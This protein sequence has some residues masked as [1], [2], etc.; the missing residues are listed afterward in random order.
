M[1]EMNRYQISVENTSLQ[2]HYK[3]KTALNPTERLS[4]M[5]KRFDT[6]DSANIPL[7]NEEQ[8]K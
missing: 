4:V 8:L 6:A 7:E 2:Y 5:V 3:Y 1:T